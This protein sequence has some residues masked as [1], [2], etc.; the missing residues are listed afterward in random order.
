MLPFWH[1]ELKQASAQQA[2]RIRSEMNLKETDKGRILNIKDQT[3][4][5]RYKFNDIFCTAWLSHVISALAKL[6]VPDV[7]RDEPTS[8][9][10]GASRLGLHAPSLYRALRAASANEIFVEHLDQKF[11]HNEASVMMKS[12]HPFSW[13]GMALM[14][15]HPSCL[16]GWSHFAD[17][18][19][20]GRSG[21]QHAF[22][23][24]LYQH[25]EELNGGTLAFSEAM[26]TGL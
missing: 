3:T 15:N 8:C 11:S 16:K 26:I 19:K 9:E 23:K 6:G 22:G 13:K 7:I 1:A 18:L 12:D 5:A 10:E 24:T 14:W 17:C 21:I 25:L 20:D 2:A 4:A